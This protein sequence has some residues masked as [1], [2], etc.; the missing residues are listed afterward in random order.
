MNSYHVK[1]QKYFPDK[2]QPS[3][4]LLGNTCGIFYSTAVVVFHVSRSQQH[5]FAWAG[6]DHTRPGT[7]L[8]DSHLR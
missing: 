6:F 2:N 1:H 3:F 8:C 7:L 4:D 5:P